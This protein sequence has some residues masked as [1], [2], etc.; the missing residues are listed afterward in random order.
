VGGVVPAHE[1]SLLRNVVDESE[2]V[3]P[4][5]IEAPGPQGDRPDAGVDPLDELRVESRVRGHE[6]AF[7]A[8]AIPGARCRPPGE[9]LPELGE[10]PLAR[11]RGRA[12]DGDG[13]GLAALAEEG[14]ERRLRAGG[15]TPPEGEGGDRGEGRAEAEHGR[16]VAR[17]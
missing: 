5:R 6:R 12:E 3:L 16:I 9:R 15:E 14:I 13:V 2:V 1:L 4:A 8:R 10:R 17:G 11:A 7:P